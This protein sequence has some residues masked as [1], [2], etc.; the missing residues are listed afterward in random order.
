MR[1][2]RVFVTMALMPLA[3][4][5]LAS[6]QSQGSARAV[7][8]VLQ[9]IIVTG[10]RDL[11]FGSIAPT[12]SKTVT[13]RQGGRFRI[14]GRANTPVLI[15]FTQLPASLGPGLVL[16]S[17]TGQRNTTN[18]NGGATSFTPVAGGSLPATLGNNGRYFIRL[19]ATL[20][21]SGATPGSYSVPVTIT[22]LYD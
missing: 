8:R 9:S 4:P 11:D 13:A 18:G 12:Q 17:W 7:A 15:Q 10:Q 5:S 6:A 22:V 19:G 20:T 14:S 21:A 16:S 2:L 1:I 3:A